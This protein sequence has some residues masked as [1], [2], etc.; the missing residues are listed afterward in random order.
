MEAGQDLAVTAKQSGDEHGQQNDG[1]CLRRDQ[2]R[3]VRSVL[4]K[5][6]RVAC[7]LDAENSMGR[8]TLARPLLASISAETGPS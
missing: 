7:K 3:H 8:N 4:L 2:R 1:R 5:G 6:G